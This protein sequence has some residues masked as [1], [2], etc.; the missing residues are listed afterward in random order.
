MVVGAPQP[1]R[2]LHLIAGAFLAA[3]MENEARLAALSITRTAWS[4]DSVIKQQCRARLRSDRE[5]VLGLMD[6][7]D[8]PAEWTTPSES[9]FTGEAMTFYLRRM[10]YPS[11]LLNLSD[12]EWEAQPSALSEVFT[13][14]G[15]WMYEH[16]T[17]RLL[18][19]GISK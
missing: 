2:D 13:M 16:H 10:A 7:L 17:Y 9:Q 3:R 5:G 1:G 4:V 18:Q 6:A 12:E 19:T 15:R 14:V 8:F 11:S